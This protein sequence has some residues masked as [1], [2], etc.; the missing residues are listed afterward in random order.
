MMKTVLAAIAVVGMAAAA[1]ALSPEPMSEAS[2]RLL[3]DSWKD[4]HNVRFSADEHEYRFNI[5]AKNAEFVRQ[6]MNRFEA[7]EETSTVALNRFA[8]LDNVEFS[9]LY[10]GYRPALESTRATTPRHFSASDLPAGFRS[11]PASV[12]WRTHS[13][14]VINPVQN[15]GQCGSCW[16]FSATASIEAA[17]ALATSNLQKFSEQEFVD[18]VNGGA[19]NCNVGGEMN[20]AFKYAIAN[21]V[22]T[23]AE[24]PY[25]ATSPGV[26]HLQKPTE[27]VITGWTPVNASEADLA[28]A[29]AVA[30]TV[31]VAVVASGLNWQLYSGGILS[32]CDNKKADLDH[33]VNVVGY[34]TSNGQAYWIVRNSWGASWGLSGY[35]WIA[36]DSGDQCGIMLDASFPTTN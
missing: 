7:G 25:T 9:R 6:H 23:E 36:K 21:G 14:P 2:A 17:H 32:N 33:G 29:I 8:H 26:C 13:P 4:M 24:Y 15:Q 28:A 30:P 1:A 3:F 35:L 34:G 19:D 12:D 27:S 22:D 18:C 20:D 5:F 31:S 10:K 11:L 16:S